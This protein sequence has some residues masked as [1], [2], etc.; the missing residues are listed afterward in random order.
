MITHAIIRLICMVRVIAQQE[1][2][3]EYCN[4]AELSW[5]QGTKRSGEDDVLLFHP[6]HKVRNKV[7]SHPPASNINGFI[8][9]A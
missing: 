3:A 4:N 8:T 1:Y 6:I 7:K 2:F 5:P 9:T